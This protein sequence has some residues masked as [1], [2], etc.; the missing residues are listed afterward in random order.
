M[1]KNH[2]KRP[3]KNFLIVLPKEF[4]RKHGICKSNQPKGNMLDGLKTKKIKIQ[5]KNI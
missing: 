4:K 1:S 2:K 3:K 5:L